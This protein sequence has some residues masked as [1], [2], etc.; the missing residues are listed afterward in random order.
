MSGE[1][2]WLPGIA[3]AVER[4]VRIGNFGLIGVIKYLI[5]ERYVSAKVQISLICPLNLFV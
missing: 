3:K 4:A 1:L 2:L 5:L